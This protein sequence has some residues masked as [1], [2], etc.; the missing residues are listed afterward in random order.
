LLA[1]ANLPNP[2][3]SKTSLQ[4][5]FDN[6]N[7]MELAAAGRQVKKGASPAAALKGAVQEKKRR[8][9]IPTRMLR[10][11]AHVKAPC[12]VVH[13]NAMWLADNWA[14]STF[15]NILANLD[16]CINPQTD[17]PAPTGLAS[18]PRGAS[19][20]HHGENIYFPFK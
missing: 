8:A 4:A 13:A 7:L 10:I 12:P 9:T 3:E 14:A 15:V 6:L 5:C 17:L 1:V 20:I 11:G 19:S 16:R 18:S 2:D